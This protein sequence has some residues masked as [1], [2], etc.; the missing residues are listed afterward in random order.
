MVGLITLVKVVQIYV[1]FEVPRRSLQILNEVCLFFY[2][3][4]FF[5]TF[6]YVASKA[7]CLQISFNALRYKCDLGSY[8]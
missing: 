4:I 3:Y 6:L 5:G 2:F 1:R 7:T 8:W